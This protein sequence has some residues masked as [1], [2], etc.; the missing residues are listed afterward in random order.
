MNTSA[1][2]GGPAVSIYSIATRWPHHSFAA[3]MQPYFFTI[4]S[5]SLVAKA[6]TTPDQFP[7]IPWQMW[8]AI[9][10]ACLVGLAIGEL[11]AKRV[12]P[13][14]SQ[15]VLIVLAYLGAAATIIRGVLDAAG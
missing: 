13:R 14:I 7:D 10:L 12:S 4:G 9:A 15:I 2:V 11:F 5:L 6:A 1:G 8:V 3:T